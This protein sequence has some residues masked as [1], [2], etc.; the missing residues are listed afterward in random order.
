MIFLVSSVFAYPVSQPVY[1]SPQY[2]S[3]QAVPAYHFKPSQSQPQV[4]QYNIQ[5][6]IQSVQPQYVRAQV[7]AATPVYEQEKEGLQNYG[8]QSPA[9]LQQVRLGFL[10]W[11][12]YWLLIWYINLNWFH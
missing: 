10:Y 8:R 2:I 6:Q 7:P 12:K 5:P 9:V 1:Q 11:E 4:L 3:A